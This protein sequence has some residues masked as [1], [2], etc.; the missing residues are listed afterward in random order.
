[1]DDGFW[2]SLGTIAN[3]PSGSSSEGSGGDHNNPVPPAPPANPAAP[4]P[5]AAPADQLSNAVLEVANEPSSA[6]HPGGQPD[7]C[8]PSTPPSRPLL[9]SDLTAMEAFFD[10]EEEMKPIIMRMH[11]ELGS[12]KVGERQAAHLVDD[13]ADRHGA[14]KM[15]E[16]LLSLRQKG[17]NSPYFAEI[18][19]DFR[20]LRA[21]KGSEANL[22]KE[23]MGIRLL[24]G[25]RQ[26]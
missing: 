18:L 10:L 16:I 17:S 5:P 2:D 1:M 4:V 24:R 22:H 12:K 19:N 6:P 21:N 20:E 8:E 9:A 3:L 14:Q 25:P 13:L 11:A 15:P 7:N 23:E 26:R